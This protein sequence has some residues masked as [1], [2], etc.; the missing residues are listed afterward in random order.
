MGKERNY[1]LN[2]FHHHFIVYLSFRSV[3]MRC[4]ILNKIGLEWITYLVMLIMRNIKVR[5]RD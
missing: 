1:I 4:S 5:L 2:Y 3:N